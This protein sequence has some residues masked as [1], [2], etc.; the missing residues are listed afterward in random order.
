MIK[1]KKATRGRPITGEAKTSTERG[2]EMEA[3]LL[4]SGGRVL[5][6][7]RLSPEAASA[8]RALSEKLGTDRAAIEYALIQT[9]K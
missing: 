4:A 2:K 7:V 6:S 3:A 8:L 5:R 1:Q 9:K